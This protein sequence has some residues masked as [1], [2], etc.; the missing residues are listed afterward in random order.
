MAGEVVNLRIAEIV[1]LTDLDAVR[2]CCIGNDSLSRAMRRSGKYTGNDYYDRAE[3]ALWAAWRAG[4]LLRDV[5]HSKPG[6]PKSVQGGPINSLNQML[7][8]HNLAKGTAHRWIAISHCHDEQIA[9]YVGKQ[10]D[11]TNPLKWS[12]IVKLGKANMPVNVPEIGDDYEMI[13][14]DLADAEV[15][16]GSVDVIITDPPYPREFIGEY[17]KLSEFAAR[18]LKPGGSC[19]AMA[20]HIYLP[21]V[22]AEMAKHLNYHWIISYLTPGGQASQVWDRKVIPSWKPVLWFVK[23]EYE[24]GWLGDVVKSDVNDNDKAHH[25]WGQSESGM[26]RLVE[27]FSKPGELIADPFVGGGTTA[28]SALTLGRRFIGIDV[29][30][31]AVDETL[32][33]IAG[34]I[35]NADA[36]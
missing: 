18:V 12:D 7:S 3:R 36:K 13:H 1:V 17:G 8:V 27:R 2:D 24:G 21:E 11:A 6:R 34:L 22:M 29:D 26:T 20:G 31:D 35:G 15:E 32:R 5:E 19:L 23:G 28:V 14:A 4:H 33:R 9:G 30:G 10:K 16:P 25:H